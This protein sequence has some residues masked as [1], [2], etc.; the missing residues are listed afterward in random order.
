MRWVAASAIVATVHHARAFFDALICYNVGYAMCCVCFSPDAEISVS[1]PSNSAD[2]VPATIKTCV[3]FI[4]LIGKRPRK[5][6]CLC[7]KTA[8]NC[9]REWWHVACSS[10]HIRSMLVVEPGEVVTCR[11]RSFYTNSNSL[12]CEI[13]ENPASFEA[14]FFVLCT[15]LIFEEVEKSLPLD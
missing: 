3:V 6:V 2:P 14:G 15:M 7:P 4:A 1:I 10:R 11:A 5:F 9:G 12:Q 8:L 13:K